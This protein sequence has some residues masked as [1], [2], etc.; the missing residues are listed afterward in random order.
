[1]PLRLVIFDCDG[2]LVD[3]EALSDRVVSAELARI[4]WAL[5]PAECHQRFLGRTLSDIQTIAEQH[6]NR[7]LGPDFVDHL[8]ACVTAA[9]AAEVEP[10][11][12]AADTVRATTALGLPFRIASNSSHTEMAAKFSR[13]GLDALIPPDRIHS[14]HDMLARGKRGKPAPDLFLTAAEAE[15]AAPSDCV[16]VEDSLAGV[17]AAIAAGIPCLA[18]V[19]EGD[20]AS[21]TALGA[22][23]FRHMSDLPPLLGAMLGDRS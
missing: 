12:G 23:L 5:T 20:G 18:Y 16:V 9:M 19:P 10:I 1:M 3:S 7:P 6:L 15:P 14:A 4:G 17:T 21:L 13:T 22:R 11:D 8:I 2:V